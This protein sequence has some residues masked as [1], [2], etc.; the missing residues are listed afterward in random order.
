MCEGQTQTRKQG[1][2]QCVP[3]PSFALQSPDT[4]LTTEDVIQDLFHDAHRDPLQLNSVRRS[5][6]F[7]RVV[8]QL[9]PDTKSL[10]ELNVEL[11]ADWFPKGQ[12]WSRP[13]LLTWYR[14]WQLLECFSVQEAPL[15]QPPAAHRGNCDLARRCE[16]PWGVSVNAAGR[17]PLIQNRACLRLSQ[18]EQVLLSP[19]GNAPEIARTRYNRAQWIKVT[20][21][22]CWSQLVNTLKHQELQGHRLGSDTL[23][24]QH[25]NPWIHG[26][27]DTS[28]TDSG[29]NSD[30]T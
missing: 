6:I 12:W 17:K 22:H 9:G 19:C 24:A 16:G 3:H 1:V 23:T 27:L 21:R 15:H 10:G 13:T 30:T 26:T 14:G 28:R 29:P 8:V 25:T 18:P 4:N 7:G 5:V 20:V 2:G 11:N